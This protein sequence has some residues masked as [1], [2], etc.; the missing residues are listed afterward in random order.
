[1]ANRKFITPATAHASMIQSANT[2]AQ[3]KAERPKR[4][5]YKAN[6]HLPAELKPYLDEMSWR[7]RMSITE[8]VAMLIYK[9]REQHPEWVETIDVLNGKK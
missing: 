3:P 8:Y 1:M 5:V 2:E 6:L 9:D 7:N 4:E